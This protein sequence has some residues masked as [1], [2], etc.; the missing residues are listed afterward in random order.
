MPSR[1]DL[2][3]RG[4]GDGVAGLTERSVVTEVFL[5]FVALGWVAR[6]SSGVAQP[7]VLPAAA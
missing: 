2:V 5:W 6:R 3:Y 7:A 4:V 1:F